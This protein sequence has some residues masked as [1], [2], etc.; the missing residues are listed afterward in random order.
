MQG[1]STRLRNRVTHFSLDLKL[2]TNGKNLRCRDR[3]VRSLKEGS[4]NLI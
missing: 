3:S 1:E 4:L 2:M